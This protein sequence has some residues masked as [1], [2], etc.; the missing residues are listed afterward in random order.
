MRERNAGLP[1]LQKYDDGQN[2]LDL[3]H[4]L[5]KDYVDVNQASLQLPPIIEWVNQV[6]ADFQ[7]QMLVAKQA[8]KE[9]E[10]RAYFDLRG[11]GFEQKY[12]GKAS[13]AALAQ[14]VVLEEKV[15]TA[16]RDYAVLY[17]H[18]QRLAN[19]MISLQAKLDLVRTVEATN[20]KVFTPP[21]T[22]S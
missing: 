1:P 14:A 9:A 19:T 4:F 17:A 2:S 20:R 16:Y 6:R 10:A 12:S 8:I 3:D 13:E 18:V 11:G 5:K 7:E 22:E 21:E 15:A